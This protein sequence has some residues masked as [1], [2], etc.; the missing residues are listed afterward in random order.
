[1]RVWLL[2][3]FQVSVGARRIEQ[4][5]WRL[6]KASAL[7]KLLALAPGHRLHREQVMDLLWPDLGKKAASNN[8]RQV[9]HAAR[10][11]LDPAQGSRYLSYQDE[12]LMLC[13]KGDLLV[14][15]DAFEE[16]AATAGRSADPAAYRA[17]IELYAGDLLPEDRYEAWAEERREQLR[18]TLLELLLELAGL[19][20]RS[21]DWEAAIQASRRVLEADPH[22]EEAHVS[23]MRINALSGRSAEA[24]TQYSALEETVRQVGAEPSASSRA[25]RDEIALGTFV[26]APAEDREGYPLYETAHAAG[27]HNLP[28]PRDNF[29]GR[30][31][32]MVEIKRTLSMTRLLTLTGAGGSGKTRLSLE[33]ARDL[34]GAYPEG[35]WLVELAPLLEGDLVAQEVAGALEISE[36]P[37]EPLAD[38][39]VDVIGSRNLLVVLDNCE[40]LAEAAARLTDTL[41]SSCPHLRV[42]ATSREPLGIPGEV[43]WRVPPLS[44]AGPDR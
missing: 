35:V 2:G 7:V 14:D 19:Y 28:A 36:R 6:K 26:A 9:L 42:L 38:T 22:R 39:L 23:L 32:E 37:G 20:E 15:V 12:L 29:V 18:K 33:I 44:Y 24:L 34:I 27:N 17:A 13:P 5:E 10:N 41:L 31:R 25:L 30:E 4:S 43:L 21:G 11:A 3:G 1:M 16:A 8:L 40:H